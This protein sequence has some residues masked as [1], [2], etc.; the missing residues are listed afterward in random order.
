MLNSKVSKTCKQPTN[1]DQNKPNIVPR[2][3]G[4]DVSEHVVVS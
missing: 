1:T 4:H 2:E 3:D